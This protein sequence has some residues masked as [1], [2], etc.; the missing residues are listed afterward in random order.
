[1]QCGDL[2]SEGMLHS[3]GKM[4][5]GLRSN[6]V[7]CQCV[8]PCSE[9][10]QLLAWVFH[11]AVSLRSQPRNAVALRSRRILGSRETLD[12]GVLTPAFLLYPFARGRGR[13][14]LAASNG[15]G[16]LSSAGI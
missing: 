8:L 12:C 11:E 4:R 7:A 6:G 3:G 13:E 9:N 16:G 15:N 14:R 10:S 5:C 2:K 1:M